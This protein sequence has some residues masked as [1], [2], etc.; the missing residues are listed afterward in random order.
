M[1][2]TLSKLV[3]STWI[4]SRTVTH[5]VFCSPEA[6]LNPNMLGGEHGKSS[7]SQRIPMS[8]Q[9][10]PSTISN[11][12]VIN[13]DLPQ[14]LMNSKFY[15]YSYEFSNPEN[16]HP[17]LSIYNMNQRDDLSCHYQPSLTTINNPYHQLLSVS[18]V[19]YDQ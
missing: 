6:L 11:Y 7:A 2:P 19:H 13:H 3:Q 5:A 15:I 4:H 9:E 12:Y 10:I 14:C 18:T 16:Q 1:M 17:Q 8:R